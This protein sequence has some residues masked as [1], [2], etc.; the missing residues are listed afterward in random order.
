MGITQ[1]IMP[2]NVP[3]RY[4]FKGLTCKLFRNMDLSS[5]FGLN[6]RFGAVLGGNRSR[7][8]TAFCSRLLNNLVYQRVLGRCFSNFL[9]TALRL[10]RSVVIVALAEL[11]VCAGGHS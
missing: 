11:R 6:S 10:C 2:P 5:I 9:K 3:Q 4:D 7:F 1:Y 8:R